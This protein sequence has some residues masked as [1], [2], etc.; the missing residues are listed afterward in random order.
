MVNSADLSRLRIAREEGRR[1]SARGGRRWLF[2]VLAVVVLGVVAAVAVLA[3]RERAVAVRTATAAVRGGG[4]GGASGLTANGYVVARTKASVSSKVAGRLAFLGV[5]EGDRVTAGAVIARLEA[6]EYEAAAR[7]AS[8]EVLAAEAARPEAEAQLA[9]ARR[10]AERARALAADS[11]LA[12]QALEDA[13]TA[14]ETADARLRAVVARV[15][16]AREAYAAARASLENTVIRA[17]FTGTVLRKDAEVGEVVAP[18]I[19]GGGLTR[20]AVV[21]MADLSTLEVEVDVSEAYIAGVRREQPA[22][23]VLDAYPEQ[24]FRGHVRQVV[25]TADRQKA[26]VLVRVAIDSEDGRILP[27]MGARV[28]FGEPGGAQAAALPARVY[29][30][31]G[32]V[33]SEGGKE[34][35]W[36]VVDGRSR[37]REVEAG[38][39]MGGEREVRRG[40]SGGETLVLEP[41]AELTDGGRVKVTG[42]TPR[43]ET[44]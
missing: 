19:A 26:T 38:P 24:T 36:V 22:E 28:V 17:P 11:L 18:S 32:A 31:A 42:D 14:L 8:A 7:Q 25:P 16:A 9:Q 40:L 1:A 39:V 43:K 6:A 3:T 2:V 12:V 44:G 15:G 33:R 34:V 41:P 37:R 13:E 23:V 27:E 29:A 35:V 21:T 30:P 10:A 20:G 5:E 4:A